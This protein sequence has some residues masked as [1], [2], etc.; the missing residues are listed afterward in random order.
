MAIDSLVK[1][2]YADQGFAVTPGLIPA[3]DWTDLAACTRVIQMTRDGTWAHRQKLENNFDLLGCKDEELQLELFNLLINPLGRNF[4][5]HWY[6]DDVSEKASEEE[7]REALSVWGHGVQWNIALYTDGC[8]YIVPNSHKIPRTLERCH[9]SETYEPPEDPMD[10]PGAI[11]LTHQPGET[12][13]YNSNILHCAA[14]DSKAKRATLHAMVGD[15][16]GGSMRARN[17]LQHG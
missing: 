3:E 1:A 12:V 5:L 10:M 7:E 14:Y 11:Q 6:R 4:A 16:H 15:I 9:L 13:F 8:L 2:T 17:T